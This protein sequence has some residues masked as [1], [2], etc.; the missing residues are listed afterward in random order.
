[1]PVLACAGVEPGAAIYHFGQWTLIA[2]VHP[3]SSA[4]SPGPYMLN[5][6]PQGSDWL[7]Y[8]EDG[9]YR[10]VSLHFAANAKDDTAVLRTND[11]AGKLKGCNSSLG[12]ASNLPSL[13]AKRP[14]MEIVDFPDDSNIIV[15]GSDRGLR[16]SGEDLI[17]DLGPFRVKITD[18]SPV[19][20]LGEWD[21]AD[22]CRYEL[23]DAAKDD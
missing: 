3:E 13:K 19:V 16:R 11:F 2:P 20:R 15:A 4:L 9:R 12:F 14:N 1:M 23:K 21:S 8:H 17:A 18:D 22:F 5:V 10:A 6:P 7:L